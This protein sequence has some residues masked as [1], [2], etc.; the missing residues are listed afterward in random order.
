MFCRHWYKPPS[1]LPA[2]AQLGVGQR[3][4][5][6]AFPTAEIPRTAAFYNNHPRARRPSVRYIVHD[7]VE[8]SDANEWEGMIGE[9]KRSARVAFAAGSASMPS[10]MPVS[11]AEDAQRKAA[12]VG[13]A[14]VDVVNKEEKM[15]A[16]LIFIFNNCLFVIWP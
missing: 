13:S 15:V 5:A 11:A 12:Y 1:E 2:H 16:V 8:K 14:P 6:R 10:V 4:L 3:D 9:E 7:F